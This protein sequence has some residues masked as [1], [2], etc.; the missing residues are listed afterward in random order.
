MDFIHIDSQLWKALGDHAR[1]EYPYECIGYFEA[2]PTQPGSLQVT[3]IFPCVSVIRGEARRESAQIA[4]KEDRNL[5]SLMRKHRDMVYGI[6]HSH[7]TGPLQISEKDRY[8]GR[9]AKRYR[10]QIIIGV[11]HKGK[12]TQKAF[13]HLESDAWTRAEFL[14]K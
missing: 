9:R 6:Y 8:W 12:R 3:K 4:K 5:I 2:R 14:V 7:P 1:R 11:Q 10:H 13:W